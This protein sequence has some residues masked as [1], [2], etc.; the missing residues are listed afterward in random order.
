LETRAD[1]HTQYILFGYVL[2]LAA[3]HKTKVSV[4]DYGGNLGDYYRLGRALVPDVKL[5]YHCKEL[6]QV[7]EAGRRLTPEVTWHTDDAALAGS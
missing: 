4:L 1:E 6:P 7:A 5:D 2:A 3:R